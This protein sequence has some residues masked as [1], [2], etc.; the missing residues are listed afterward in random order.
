MGSKEG[1]WRN[2][3]WVFYATNASLNL[4]PKRI[5]QYMLTK[6]NLNL[7]KYICRPGFFA[8][9]TYWP[10]TFSSKPS[11]LPSPPASLWLLYDYSIAKEN[12]S[13]LLQG[14]PRI[15]LLCSTLSLS[16]IPCSHGLFVPCAAVPSNQGPGPT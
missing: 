8:G 2:E 11:P 6:L 15:L 13:P 9:G 12:A 14:L 5:I 3:H 16:H 7:K 10:Q 4:P 1:T